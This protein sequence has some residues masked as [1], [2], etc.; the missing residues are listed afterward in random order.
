MATRLAASKFKIRYELGN[1]S[2][3]LEVERGN[4]ENEKK[5]MAKVVEFQ[6]DIINLNVGGVKYTTSLTTLQK[7]RN[8]FHFFPFLFSQI[9]QRI[10]KPSV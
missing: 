3:S 6:G 7:V 2:A 1:V 10:S 4:I 8:F 5:M 9:F